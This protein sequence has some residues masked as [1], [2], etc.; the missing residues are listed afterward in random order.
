M[1]IRPTCKVSTAGLN[2]AIKERLRYPGRT[3]AQAVNT[4]AYWIA[5]NTKNATPFA[6]IEAMDASL[7]RFEIPKTLI[8][9]TG[10]VSFRGKRFFYSRRGAKA[11]NE[12]VPLTALIIAARVKKGDS[13]PA[14]WRLD[15][16][17]FKGVTRKQ[18]QAAMRK[19]VEKMLKGRHSSAHFLQSGWVKAVRIL[20]QYAV[21]KK[22]ADANQDMKYDYASSVRGDATVAHEGSNMVFAQIINN[23]GQEGVNAERV[24]EMLQKYG[25]APLQRAIDREES[26]LWRRISDLNKPR[27]DK[28]NQMAK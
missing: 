15:K 14:K 4:A 27:D 25:T 22:P 28:F 20:E 7:G 18:G 23:T 16:N 3:E 17:P 21:G 19:L 1:E 24:D 2:A 9:K 8:T 10:E 12:E 11:G 26:Q 6:S 5:V 13:I